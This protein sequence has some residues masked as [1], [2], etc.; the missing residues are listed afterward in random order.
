VHLHTYVTDHI[1][2]A[3]Q[4]AAFV[5]TV[6]AAML[7]YLFKNDVHEMWLKSIAA[8]SLLD[9]C[10][11]VAMVTLALS[12]VAAC[13]VVRPRLERSHDGT[14]FFRCISKY[15]SAAEYTADVLRG[16]TDLKEALLMHV[17]DL[18]RVCERKYR[19]LAFSIWLGM[20]GI[21]SSIVVLLAK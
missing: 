19:V 11:F 6:A 14:V 4:K 18:S 2:L 17:F 20:L 9:G 10:A 1:K 16:D 8:W 21:G 7:C 12:L 5:F 3:D 15:P 13:L